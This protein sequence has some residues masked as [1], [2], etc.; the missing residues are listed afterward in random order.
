MKQPLECSPVELVLI[1]MLMAEGRSYHQTA[2]SLGRD[3]HTV[4]KWALRLGYP[5][6]RKAPH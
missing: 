6:N 5:S 3:V 2:L 1:A 4:R